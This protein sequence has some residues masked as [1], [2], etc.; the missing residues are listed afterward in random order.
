[1]RYSKPPL[2]FEQQ[3]DQLINRGMIGDRSKMI[4]RL[5]VVNYYR[6]SAYWFPFRVPDPSDLTHPTDNFRPGTDFDAVWKRYVF[7]RRLRLQVMDALERIEVCVRTQLAYHHAHQF[8]DAFSYVQNPAAL[9]NFNTQRRTE[10]IDRIRDESDRSRDTFV[11]HFRTKYGDTH[12]FMPVWMATE[13]MTFGSVLSFYNAV[14]KEI[15]KKVATCFGVHAT[16]LR[17]WLLALN[18]IRN[19]CAH[20]GRLWNRELGNKP[21]IPNRDPSWQTPVVVTNNRMFGILTILRYSLKRVAPQSHWVE[22][23]QA[24]IDEF[25]MIPIDRMGFPEKWRACPI[26]NGKT[27]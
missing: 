15:Q 3:A 24:L 7:D 5:Q 18:T 1:M 6:L 23:F 22:R 10:F 9:P 13:I 2:T 27:S 25:P 14:D 17:S 11:E 4:E 12:D 21:L 20:H 26:W 19:M 8:T 16:V